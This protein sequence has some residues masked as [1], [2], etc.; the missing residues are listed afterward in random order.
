MGLRELNFFMF[1]L[2]MIFI[3]GFICAVIYLDKMPSGTSEGVYFNGEDNVECHSV[4]VEDNKFLGTY[5]FEEN[6]TPFSE[7]KEKLK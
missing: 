6:C 5:H 3:F 7:N 2:L 4:K 1:V